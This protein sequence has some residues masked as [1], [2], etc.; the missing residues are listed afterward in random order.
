MERP[1]Q[2][3]LMA[4]RCNHQA[5]YRALNELS[6]YF[7]TPSIIC[8][9]SLHN[10]LMTFCSNT[11]GVNSTLKHMTHVGSTPYCMHAP[12]WVVA[13][14]Q[15]SHAHAELITMEYVGETID[16]LFWPFLNKMSS[17]KKNSK[18]CTFESSRMCVWHDLW[19]SLNMTQLWAMPTRHTS[20]SVTLSDPWCVHR[21][22][23]S[24][25]RDSVMLDV[26]VWLVNMV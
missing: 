8:T 5:S 22:R 21:S 20:A 9:S 3:L 2:S 7:M 6:Y 14:P 16:P 26:L 1:A 12:R 25:R 23:H 4:A 19:R 11:S 15:D 24:R 18:S 10:D 17:G 13:A